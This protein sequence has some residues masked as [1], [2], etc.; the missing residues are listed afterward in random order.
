VSSVQFLIGKTLSKYE[1]VEHLGHGGMAEVYKAQ[2][3]KLDRMVALKVLHPFLAEEE[4]FVAR[5]EREARMVATL[6]HPNIVQ[7]YDFDH[8]AEYDV[9]YMVMEYIDGPTLKSRL[10]EGV[11]PPEEAARITAAIA[12]AL[13]YAH[14]RGMVHRDIKPANIMFTA[15]GQPVL[16]DFGI[17]RMVSVSGLTASGAMVGTPAYMAPEVGMGQS[18]LGAS[19]IYS[20]G[21]VLYQLA[22]GRLPFES[23]IPMGLVMQHINDPVPLPSK[24]S[25]QVSHSLEAVIL[26]SLAK[27]PEER[28]AS[29]ADM[30]MAL[31]SAVGLDSPPGLITT[32]SM[33]AMSSPAESAPGASRGGG[34]PPISNST[35]TVR[36]R[37][38]RVEVAFSDDDVLDRTWPPP[39][40]VD[41]PIID[42]PEE[43]APPKRTWVRTA[44]I[45]SLGV[46]IVLLAVGWFI[47]GGQVAG[48]AGLLGGNNPTAT[49]PVVVSGSPTPPGMLVT[50]ISPTATVDVV[51]TATTVGPCVYRMRVDP[52]RM[53][54]SGEGVAPGSILVA[55]LTLRNTGNCA[56]PEDGQLTLSSGEIMSAPQGLAV[57][58][59]LPGAA[60]QLLLPLIAPMTPG[61]Y[62]AIWEVSRGDGKVFGGPIVVKVVVADLPTATALPGSIRVATATPAPLLTVEAPRLIDWQEDPALGT[63]TATLE[64]VVSGGNGRYQ[65]YQEKIE[66]GAE[67]PQGRFIVQ[68]A[69]CRAVPLMLW[70]LSEEQVVQWQGTIPYPAPDRCGNP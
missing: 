30:A 11:L 4:G 50:E 39:A 26:R 66:P 12:D 35:I 40:G 58:P 1:V 65:I 47:T 5:F 68:G 32:S 15:E 6:R 10:Q 45:S 60:T 54:P 53:M 20:L 70:V 23:E 24:V 56:W 37:P 18:G 29:A 69:R 2:Q 42:Q 49:V 44:L 63:W 46:L 14:R 61:E 27:K 3:V 43:P 48:L 8:S 22:T 19:D 28:Y 36:P 13:D 9:Y 67:A 25:P 52:I 57:A 41:I 55:Y 62:N 33:P 21:V 16:T 7:V 17:A 59:V 34:T 31:R 38:E 51:P 64:A